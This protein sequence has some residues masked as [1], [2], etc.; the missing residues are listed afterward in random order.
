MRVLYFFSL[1]ASGASIH[2][3]GYCSILCSWGL[4]RFTAQS[5][6][7]QPVSSYHKQTHIASPP[8][9]LITTLLSC[10]LSYVRLHN[11]R[12]VWVIFHNLGVP[13]HWH[14]HQNPSGVESKV[15]GRFGGGT[16]VTFPKK[17][18]NSKLAAQERFIASIIFCVCDRKLQTRNLTWKTFPSFS[19]E[20]QWRSGK[21][22]S[23]D[24]TKQMHPPTPHPPSDSLCT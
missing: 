19:W 1:K 18:N 24:A 14:C 22:R 13:L 8:D 23:W 15:R 7:T 10:R 4:F 12:S 6:L 21:G 17:K 5:V 11:T 20:L 16:N 3:C 2:M 9:P